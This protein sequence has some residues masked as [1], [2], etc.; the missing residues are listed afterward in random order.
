MFAKP[1]R[2]IGP[3]VQEDGAQPRH[4][5]T[6]IRLHEDFSSDAA[7]ELPFLRYVRLP[8]QQSLQV[9]G[10]GLSII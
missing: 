10:P 1:R 7:H 3:V 5:V 6:H 9:T 4:A 2:A 8:L